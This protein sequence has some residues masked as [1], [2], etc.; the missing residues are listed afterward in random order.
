M[1]SEHSFSWKSKSPPLSNEFF[2]CNSDFPRL[3]I[4]IL[5]KKKLSPVF[6]RYAWEVEEQKSWRKPKS[7]GEV[8]GHFLS[9]WRAYFHAKW[10]SQFRIGFNFC[11][12][13]SQ[14]KNKKEDLVIFFHFHLLWLYMALWPI[15]LLQKRK[16][17][18]ERRRERFCVRETQKAS[19]KQSH[20]FPGTVSFINSS[21]EIW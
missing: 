14:R 8:T 10:R 5:Q 4:H 21:K 13:R 16:S 2:W 11:K 20:I 1:I 3:P 12:W 6:K 19:V 9:T 17:L 7:Q 15:V 18:G